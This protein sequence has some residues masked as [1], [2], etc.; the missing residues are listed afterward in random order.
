MSNLD[1]PNGA[2]GNADQNG[3]TERESRDALERR[4]RELEK[5]NA[6]LQTELGESQAR[7]A[8]ERGLLKGMILDDLP[9]TEAE[10]KDWTANSSSFSELLRGLER[11]FGL[12]P[13]K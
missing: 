1:E 6:R 12:E 2:A 8:Q 3:D 7:L 5:E 4:V 9:Q 10:Y 13:P 11:E